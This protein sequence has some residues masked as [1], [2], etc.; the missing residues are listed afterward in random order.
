LII[1]NCVIC[2]K[3]LFQCGVPT[4]NVSFLGIWAKIFP[5]TFVHAV[6]TVLGEIPPYY[7]TR[8][9]RRASMLAAGLVTNQSGSSVSECDNDKKD[10]DSSE[11]ALLLADIDVEIAAATWWAPIYFAK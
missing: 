1:L 7:M 8:S 10:D 2:S 11:V 4:G 5:V 6:G 3:L 9:A